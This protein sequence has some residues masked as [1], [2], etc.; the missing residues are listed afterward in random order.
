MYGYA[1]RIL[2]VLL[3]IIG[4]TRCIEYL[5]L[6]VILHEKLWFP[7]IQQLLIHNAT[8]DCRLQNSIN[9]EIAAHSYLQSDFGVIQ[10]VRS[11]IC[12]ST[13]CVQFLRECIVSPSVIRRIQLDSKYTMRSSPFHTKQLLS[14]DEMGNE[15][16]QQ[17]FISSTIGSKFYDNGV[18][19]SGIKVAIFDTGLNINHPHFNNVQLRTNWTDEDESGDN[20][21]HGSFVCGIIAGTYE[22]CPGLAPDVDLYIFR[23]F[24]TEQNS[25]TSWFLDA[26]NYAIFI[27]VDVI[28]LSIGGPDHEDKPFIDKLDE[29]TANGIT[30]VSAIGND[31]PIWGT[32][33]SPAD[34]MNV[35]GVG[36]WDHE[37]YVAEFSSRG[38]TTWEIPFGMGRVKPDI[39]APSVNLC[40]SE[41]KDPFGCILLSGTSVAGP[42][43]TG[44]IALILATVN[45]TERHIIRNFAALKQIIIASAEKLPKVSMFE[46]GAG[47]LDLTSAYAHA[48]SFAPHV[49]LH[50]RLI[51]NYPEECPHMWPWCVQG[52]YDTS[53]PLLVN[54]TVFNSV[55]LTGRIV[56]VSLTKI[57]V[58]V[59]TASPLLY[60]PPSTI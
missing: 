53:Q 21:G 28:N 25:Y 47:L 58:F 55:A 23:V 45:D 7:E 33:F 2:A 57:V 10:V 46:Q 4:T 27:G 35:I 36:G 12:D 24:T 56:E 11:G 22:E 13:T 14:K 15:N 38:M 31:G 42:V 32:L 52:L 18:T 19:G 50:P 60:T 41:A 29:V 49:S 48:R 6:L 59:A 37:S 17:R 44:A 1:M 26:F 51:S 5:R 3:A 16:V 39:L 30:I 9:L 43:I 8:S 40:S 54:F 34:Q 20:V